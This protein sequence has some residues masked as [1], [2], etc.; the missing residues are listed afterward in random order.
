[1]ISLNLLIANCHFIQG[2]SEFDP[3][4]FAE[5][6]DPKWLREAELKHGRVA[7]LAVTGYLVQE[8]FRLPGAID[9][10][11][12]TFDSI[13]NGI[14]AVGKVPSAGWLQIIFSI[15]YWDLIGS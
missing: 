13:P 14:A 1:M 8:V 5:T 6:F 9:L 15:G 2:N 4:G 3:F 12:T 10:D 11:G 7:M